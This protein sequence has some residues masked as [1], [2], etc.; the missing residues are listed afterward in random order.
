MT[1]PRKLFS[2]GLSK[3]FF[4]KK[5]D[6]IFHKI[7]SYPNI[8]EIEDPNE[9]ANKLLK[10]YKNSFNLP[11]ILDQQINKEKEENWIII[12]KIPVKGN[13]EFLEY[14]PSKMHISPDRWYISEKNIIYKKRIGDSSDPSII[15]ENIAKA[16]K[17][18]REELERIKEALLLVKNEIDSYYKKNEP[19]LRSVMI[20][21]IK[22]TKEWKDLNNE[23]NS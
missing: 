17:I 7:K 19:Q 9:F 15:K 12:F 2:I 5:E 13:I 11:I 16:E 14:A 18:M 3:N 1:N 4:D 23:F 20:D 6:M 21:K 8:L 10:E 22:K